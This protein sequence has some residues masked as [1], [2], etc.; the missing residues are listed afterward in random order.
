QA[1]GSAGCARIPN[2]RC[3]PGAFAAEGAGTALMMLGGLSGVALCARWFPE[4][5]STRLLFIGM[6]FGACVTLV[7]LSPLGRR[8]GAH[9][10]PAVTLAFA[11][12]GRMRPRDVPPY[13]AVQLAGALA[14][15][16]A[17]RALWGTD[18]TGVTHIDVSIPAALG[19]E[20]AMTALLI[21]TILASGGLAPLAV[22]PVIV[23][24]T[25]QGSPF[26]GTSLNPARSAGPALAFQDLADL[27][28]YFPAPLAG[29]LLAAGV[30]RLAVTRPHRHGTGSERKADP[31]PEGAR[32]QE[33]AGHRRQLG[34]R[35]GHRGAVRGVRRERRDQLPPAA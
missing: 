4:S 12:L 3:G 16:L 35:P 9:L 32:G 7:A 22:W 10:N 18:V 26:T 21:G 6:L 23:L 14:G 34:D 30:T 19:L 15:S 5:Q 33:R 25:W 2:G 24:L 8:S 17:F 28:I 27:W 29:A 20:L 11:A 31:G 13:V 1:A